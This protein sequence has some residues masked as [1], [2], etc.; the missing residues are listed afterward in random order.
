[1]ARSNARSRGSSGGRRPGRGATHPAS[2]AAARRQPAGPGAE[3]G[4][5]AGNHC[6]GRSI[7]YAI[8]E[9]TLQEG[10][11]RAVADALLLRPMPLLSLNGP[12]DAKLAPPYRH[13]ACRAKPLD[14]TELGAPLR[15]GLTP[16]VPRSRPGAGSTPD[17]VAGPCSPLSSRG[18]R[19]PLPD[20]PRPRQGDGVIRH[21]AGVARPHR[22]SPGTRGY[23]RAVARADST[24]DLAAAASLSAGDQQR[25]LG[26][27]AVGQTLRFR[28]SANIRRRHRCQIHE[29]QRR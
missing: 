24:R 23:C 12:D 10:D 21:A 5:C 27:R 18:P 26:R 17:V 3:H 28:L 6:E 22:I 13:I 2:P 9:R 15:T 11:T 16:C 19:K 25:R 7:D 29:L 20:R 14:F 8:V 1:M 4:L